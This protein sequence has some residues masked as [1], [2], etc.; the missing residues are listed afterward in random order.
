[1]ETDALD[2]LQRVRSLI[3]HAFTEFGAIPDHRASESMLIRGGFFCGRR[4]ESG[5]F[6]AVWF[7][8]ENEVKFFDRDGA[9]IRVLN[10]A[11]EQLD[12]AT[13]KAA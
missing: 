6:Q 9:V 5:G 11:P 8:E 4:F 2:A 12:D 13:R 10:L 7:A 1:M 3:Q